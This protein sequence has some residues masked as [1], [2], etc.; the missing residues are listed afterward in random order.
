VGRGVVGQANIFELK[1]LTMSRT[2]LVA[3]TL[4][5]I[6]GAP[7]AARAQAPAAPAAHQAKV[8][9]DKVLLDNDRVRVSEIRLGPGAKIELPTQPNQFAYLLTD[10]T[11][12]FSR[13]GHTPY[14]LDFKAGEATLLPAQSTH[15]QNRS[16]KEVR[17]VLVVLKEGGHRGKSRGKSRP[18]K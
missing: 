17:A 11:L 9:L 6:V 1:E 18:A 12:V 15:A 8:L 13:P 5:A 2:G 16:N 14:E 7:M 10:A 3:A 4:L